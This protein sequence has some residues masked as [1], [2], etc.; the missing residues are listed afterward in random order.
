MFSWCVADG[1]LYISAVHNRMVF[2]TAW[3][4]SDSVGLKPAPTTVHPLGQKTL[5]DKANKRHRLEGR[6]NTG[7][8]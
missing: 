8:I 1:Q 4:C 7:A 3:I 2:L 6:D 5:P